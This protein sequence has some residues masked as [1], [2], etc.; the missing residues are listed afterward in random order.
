MAKR[1]RDTNATTIE[2]RLKEGRGQGKGANYTPW[3]HLQKHPLQS[4]ARIVN[5]TG[6]I[7]N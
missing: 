3:I 7:Q 6:Y 1:K 5:L 4:V 2:N